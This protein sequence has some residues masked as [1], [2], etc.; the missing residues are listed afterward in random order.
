MKQKVN[1]IKTTNYM[2]KTVETEPASTSVSPKK[3]TVKK[4]PKA[5]ANSPGV[6]GFS[7]SFI[8]PGQFNN[9]LA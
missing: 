8:Q 1:Q 2:A 3:K 7:Q 4:K 6:R 5:K 9:G